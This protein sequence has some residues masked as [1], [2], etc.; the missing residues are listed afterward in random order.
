[1]C[2]A[3][4]AVG[5]DSSTMRSSD[6]V[7]ALGSRELAAELEQRGRALGLAPRGLVEAGVLER[8]GG[9]AGEHL[10]QA[11]VVLVELVEAELRDHDHADD[12]RPVGQ[13]HDDQR[14]L[15]QRPCRGCTRANSQLAASPISS[16]SPV[17][18]DAARD[19][20]AD[21]AREDLERLLT[22]P[23]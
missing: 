9:V 12:A 23:T 21:L 3:S 18:G 10:E 22:S 7:E 2:A 8:D 20:L 14:L 16:D 17:C 6:L 11:D 1:M 15:D 13:R 5:A 19:A 4:R